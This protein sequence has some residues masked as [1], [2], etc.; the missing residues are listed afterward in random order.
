MDD[1]SN[2]VLPE[3]DHGHSAESKR[4][5]KIFNNSYN[6]GGNNLE[7]ED[8]SGSNRISVSQ[9]YANSYLKDLYDYEESLESNAILDNIYEFIKT[10]PPLIG[11]MRKITNNIGTTKIKLTKP[12]V[13]LIFTR[14]NENLDLKS[15]PTAFY[16]PIYI[17]EVISSISSIEYKKLFDMMDTDIQE[18]LLVE[19]NK[20][21]GFLS[22]KM[23]KKRSY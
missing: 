21:Y 20:K 8:S 4:E 22:G 19:L 9:D 5:D 13:N 14:V 7:S 3:D 11:I 16:C 17:L 1:T 10:D 23:N 12:E 18:I 6:L 15:N 2:N